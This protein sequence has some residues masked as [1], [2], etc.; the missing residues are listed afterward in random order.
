MT[1]PIRRRFVMQE[2]RDAYRHKSQILTGSQE[3]FR[4]TDSSCTSS[5]RPRQL[6]DHLFPPSIE[7]RVP[8][9]YFC[10]RKPRRVR[11]TVPREGSG[12]GAQLG[13]QPR[14]RRPTPVLDR[15]LARQ[16]AAHPPRGPGPTTDAK[17]RHPQCSVTIAFGTTTP[18]RKPG[19]P[20][21]T[22]LMTWK[23]PAWGGDGEPRPRL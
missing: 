5:A 10:S 21:G 6:R 1:C 4:T 13:P 7:F 11:V 15:M 3:L 16:V 14:A 17:R 9:D 8:K 18:S 2:W 19:P 22:S 20:A 12:V 23:I